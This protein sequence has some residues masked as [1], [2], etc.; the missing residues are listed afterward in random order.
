MLYELTPPDLH[1]KA[2]GYLFGTIHLYH[3]SF[4]TWLQYATTFLEQCAVY[5]PEMDISLMGE[6]GICQFNSSNASPIKINARQQSFFHKHFGVDLNTMTHLPLEALFGVVFGTL[7]A[8]IITN[9]SIDQYL[10]ETAVKKGIQ[11]KGLE[12]LETQMKIMDKI[13][14][15]SFRKQLEKMI[16]SPLKVNALIKQ[17]LE[18]YSTGA[19]DR[20]Y[21]TGKKQSAKDKRLLIYD[22][23]RTMTQTLVESF[24][25][26][27]D[28]NIF[29]A[30]GCGHIPG[31]MGM[32]RYLKKANFKVKPIK[33]PGT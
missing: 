17:M 8:G 20:L 31:E 3:P 14:D 18:Y 5:C 7:T 6:N 11:I 19:I 28:S 9:G 32:L 30:V 25:Q 29:A 23:N 10:Y 2:K 12:S 27:P 15:S 21:K 4:D 33:L 16:K 26:N 13:K 1:C 24:N 22:R